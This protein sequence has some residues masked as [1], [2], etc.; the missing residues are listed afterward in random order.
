[1][2]MPLSV[3]DPYLIPLDEVDVF[4]PQLYE[5]DSHWPYFE[6]LRRE[7]PFHYCRDS[8]FGPYWSITRMAIENR[9]PN[10]FLVSRFQ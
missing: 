6:R 9:Y 3:T 7:T 4:D 1:M 5:S 8:L 2:A 10:L